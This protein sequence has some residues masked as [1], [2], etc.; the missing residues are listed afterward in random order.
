M[1]IE[2]L[3]FSAEIHF[4]VGIGGSVAITKVKERW[5]SYLDECDVVKVDIVEYGAIELLEC[6][7]I[8]LDKQGRFLA[9]VT[10]MADPDEYPDY[11]LL[12]L[13]PV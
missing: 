3:N 6:I 8:D 5:I 13:S 12:E 10:G 1:I 7:G 9:Q 11:E 4:T 2:D